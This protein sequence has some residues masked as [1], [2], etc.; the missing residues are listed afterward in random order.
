MNIVLKNIFMILVKNT[1]EVF[2]LFL[3][4]FSCCVSADDIS[5]L[6]I[7]EFKNIKM[8]NIDNIELPQFDL[9]GG[10]FYVENNK[11]EYDRRMKPLI[12]TKIMFRISYVIS[13]TNNKIQCGIS[14]NKAES[15][16]YKITD[17]FK[18]YFNILEDI[19]NNIIKEKTIDKIFKDGGV[20]ISYNK[21]KITIPPRR[22]WKSN[23]EKR[24][25]I[26]YEYSKKRG[27]I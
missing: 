1:Q 7:T 6:S 13:F 26:Y 17:D 10:S 15:I 27:G 8:K 11:V 24:K 14:F 25:G 16:P 21:G 4:L 19:N 18:K 20:V 5:I 9:S 3:L 2:A 22:K 12:S 23:I